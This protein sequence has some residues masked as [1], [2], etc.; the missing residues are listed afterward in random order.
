MAHVY[1]NQ[2]NDID[3]MRV[4]DEVARRDKMLE[5]RDL[6]MKVWS[7]HSSS[8]LLMRVRKDSDIQRKYSE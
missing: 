1:E 6:Y 8:V 2:D 5:F 4:M 7:L 3:F